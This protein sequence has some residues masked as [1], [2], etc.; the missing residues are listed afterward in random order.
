MALE[1][2][3]GFVLVFVFCTWLSSAAAGLWL[4]LA[5]SN[6]RSLGAAVEKRAASLSLILP[7]LLGAI[8]T[9]SIAAMALLPGISDH[10][11]SHPQHL[12][13]CLVH[14]DQ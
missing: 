11:N 8:V 7:P 14:G 2:L 10:C 4:L 3:I 5:R 12:H 1:S 6:L 13:L 9:L